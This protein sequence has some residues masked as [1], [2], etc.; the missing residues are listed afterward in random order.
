MFARM[1]FL[2]DQAWRFGIVASFVWPALIVWVGLAFVG[3]ASWR[4]GNGPA[5]GVLSMP[6]AGWLALLAVFPLAMLFIGSA[7]WKAASS[8]PSSHPSVIALYVLAL[9][10]V[11]CAYSLVWGFR[12]RRVLAL[13]TSILGIA[14]GLGAFFISGF[15]LSGTWP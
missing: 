10:Q 4:R 3:L 1:P 6:F 9:L 15:A 7:C 11:L 8:A 12:A 2:L 5:P 13:S 14:W